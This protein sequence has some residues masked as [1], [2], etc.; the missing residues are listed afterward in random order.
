MKI[1]HYFDDPE[2]DICEN[3]GT[4]VALMDCHPREKQYAMMFGLA[5]KMLRILQDIKP[6]PKNNALGRDLIKRIREIKKQ[7]E[8]YPLLG[9]EADY[10]KKV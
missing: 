8:D 3:D 10:E 4:L 6:I 5:P 2:F 1:L 9:H 7:F